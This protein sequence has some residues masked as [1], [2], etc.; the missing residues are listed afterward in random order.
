M[1]LQIEDI[2]DLLDAILESL[3]YSQAQFEDIKKQCN[4][5]SDPKRLLNL[6]KDEISAV[7]EDVKHFEEGCEKLNN[8]PPSFHKAIKTEIENRKIA[9]LQRNS[10]IPHLAR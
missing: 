2:L 5:V 8:L 6:I 4:G 10:P 9:A 3:Q 1:Q 7:T